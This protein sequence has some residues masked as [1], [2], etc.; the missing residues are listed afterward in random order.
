MPP[1]VTVLLQSVRS[2]DEA[3]QQDLFRLVHAELRTLARAQ[4]RAERDGHTLGATDLVHE[5]YLRLTGGQPSAWADRRHFYATAAQAMRHV[6]VD[7]A[8]ARRAAKRGGSATPLSLDA[9][10]E[11]GLDLPDEARAEFVLALDEA[12]ERL[13]RLDTRKARVAECRYI[14]GLSVEETAEALG[15]SCSTVKTDWAFARTWLYREI[16]RAD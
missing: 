1:D 2:G 7:W 15:V 16:Q 5:A 6:L 13:S 12:L 14:A 4:L 3:A 11:G 9:L 8:R 10:R